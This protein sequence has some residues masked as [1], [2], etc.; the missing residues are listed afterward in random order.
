MRNK[1][2]SFDLIDDIN[3]FKK[4]VARSDKSV[5]VPVPSN[6]LDEEKNCKSDSESNEAS[7]M[8]GLLEKVR[9][10]IK[11]YSGEV[12]NVLGHVND[13]I[14]S[15]IDSVKEIGLREIDDPNFNI[16]EESQK[17]GESK[18]FLKNKNGES[19]NLNSLL[20]PRIRFK[21]SERKETFYF[22][23]NPWKGGGDIVFSEMNNYSALIMTLLH[24]I[25]HTKEDRHLK[26]RSLSSRFKY[27]AADT[28]RRFIFNNNLIKNFFKGGFRGVKDFVKKDGFENSMPLWYI[29]EMNKL[30]SKSERGAWAYSLKK[31]RELQKNGYDVFSGFNDKSEVIA[32]IQWCLDTYER[33]RI[34]DISE[35]I[36]RESDELLSS[37]YFKQIFSKKIS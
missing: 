6:L 13:R 32:Y 30:R 14:L 18:F 31:M 27:L 9:E 26:S 36:S 21:K 7:I 20:P 35:N 11:N 12:P 33:G 17:K 19:F 28:Q 22:K 1:M 16:V 25:G 23:Y 15:G 24:E 4:D 8:D 3:K 37:D 2:H 5:E 10:N 34:I 29:E